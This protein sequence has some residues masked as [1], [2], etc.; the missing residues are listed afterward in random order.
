MKKI[1][2]IVVF[3]NSF[4]NLYGEPSYQTHDYLRLRVYNLSKTD[5]KFYF[6]DLQFPLIYN[7]K[8]G[9][10]QL[11]MDYPVYEEYPGFI[12]IDRGDGNLDIFTPSLANTVRL[13]WIFAVIIFDNSVEFCSISDWVCDDGVVVLHDDYVKDETWRKSHVSTRWYKYDLNDK[14]ITIEIE[15]RANRTI[16]IYST[17]KNFYIENYGRTIL[18]ND[19]TLTY[20]IND[21]MFSLKHIK[22]EIGYRDGGFIEHIY[23]YND[24]NS[25]H[26]NIKIII[27]NYDS[28]YEIQYK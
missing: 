3:L 25:R 26:K 27:N 19:K 17:G 5:I 9:E 7:L 13:H 16:Y 2:I 18:D 6:H 21:S 11:T 24:E 15:N 1:I 8:S 4:L 22:F 14:I 23:L 20:E 12:A 28:G 10:S